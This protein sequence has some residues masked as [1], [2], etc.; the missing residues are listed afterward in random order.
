MSSV[1]RRLSP[2]SPLEGG[3]SD[4]DL[5]V[6]RMRNVEK[7]FFR[8]GREG[9]WKH[10]EK[11]NQIHKGMVLIRTDLSGS[12]PIELGNTSA[13]VVVIA[14]TCVSQTCFPKGF[15]NQ[16]GYFNRSPFRAGHETSYNGWPVYLTQIETVILASPSEQR[17]EVRYV[18]KVA[19]H[20]N[21]KGDCLVDFT[22]NGNAGFIRNGG[23]SYRDL[24]QEILGLTGGD[25]GK[26]RALAS[27]LLRF[28]KNCSP[29]T[30]EDLG[31]ALGLEESLVLPEKVAFMNTL[32]Y[33]LFVK[34]IARRQDPD[35]E[36]THHAPWAISLIRALRLVEAGHVRLQQVLSADA[37]YGAFTGANVGVNMGV[38]I[39]KIKNVN[40]L[41]RERF[42]ETPATL[43]SQDPKKKATARFVLK[44][45][46]IDV[47]GG[48]SDTDSSGYESSGL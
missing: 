19:P 48:A 39:R 37:A 2:S 23:G 44:Q 13:R 21:H 8:T 36:E 1:S 14:E 7:R 17:A 9:S 27:L 41:Y 3:S 26:E 35:N 22:H 42:P 38:A 33:L 32:G 6:F 31:R 18:Q 11:L 25:T 46:L 16:H 45:E 40:K 12:D 30:R 47:Y 5:E 20:K 43:S 15:S 10:A 24:W 4:S 29:I 34:E 28:A